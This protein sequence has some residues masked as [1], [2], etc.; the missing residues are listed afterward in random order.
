MRR[1]RWFFLFVPLWLVLLIAFTVAGFYFAFHAPAIA[2]MV[3]CWVLIGGGV[4]A[5]ALRRVP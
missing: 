5:I 1:R 2:A 3:L 4:W